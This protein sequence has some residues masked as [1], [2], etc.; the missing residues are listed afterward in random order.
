MSERMNYII[1]IDE[2]GTG[3]W[4]GPICV[5]AVRVNSNWTLA[6]LNDSKKCTP[7]RREKLR[8]KLLQ[9]HLSGELGYEI[10][11][12]SVE[13]IN[14]QGLGPSLRACQLEVLNKLKLSGK[15]ESTDQVILDGQGNSKYGSDFLGY[16]PTFIIKADGKIPAVMA[17][18]IL[19]KTHRDNLMKTVFHLQHPEYNWIKNIGYVT[20]DHKEAVKKY[21]LCSLHRKYNVKMYVY[22]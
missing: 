19:A 9:F 3:A 12:R 15:Y 1:G 14:A 20:P 6:G 4:A 13:E 18:S 2:V 8:N 17:A 7:I 11:E 5:C 21:G 16:N 10:A 22:L